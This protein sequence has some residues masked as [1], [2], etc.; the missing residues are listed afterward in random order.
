M[1][2]PLR[3][4]EIFIN[5]VGNAVKFTERGEVTVRAQIESETE[6]ALVLHIEVSDTGIGIA[7]EV[8]PRLFHPF[9]QGD[10][11]STR[12]HGGTGLGLVITKHIVETMGGSISV[13]S[14]VLKG[15]T[16]SLTL[17]LDKLGHAQGLIGEPAGHPAPGDAES[18]APRKHALRH[19][20]VLLV[21]DEPVN[22]EVLKELLLDEGATVVLA[23]DGLVALEL[24]RAGG[25]DLV[26]MDMRMPHLDGL[27]ATRAIRQLP[28]WAHTPIVALTANAFVEDRQNCLAAGMNEFL[29]KPVDPDVFVETLVRL[30]PNK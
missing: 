6:Q 21:E 24:A 12:K 30:L 10:G 19:A 5:L 4:K 9:E 14:E 22:R 23:E 7:P 26:L 11:S 8:M 15:T 18:D 17:P 2:D 25:Y 28:G 13:S 29:T 3:L 27:S 20:R 16:I 1:G